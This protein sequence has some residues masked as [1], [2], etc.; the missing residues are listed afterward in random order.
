MA[1][2][3]FLPHHRILLR[4]C[5]DH[6][7]K[8]WCPRPLC[9]PVGPQSS[10]PPRWCP[11]ATQT[12]SAPWSPVSRSAVSNWRRYRCSENTRRTCQRR[13]RRR[14]AVIV[15][16]PPPPT[17]PRCRQVRYLSSRRPPRP[18][19]PSQTLR[20]RRTT[21]PPYHRRPAVR[22]RLHPRLTR[23]HITPHRFLRGKAIPG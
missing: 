12:W 23:P 21:R 5:H 2:A 20:R 4:R 9:S 18:P 3:S 14:R 11:P 15:P 1:A 10:T 7:T 6:L 17:V 13:A 22:C 16:C 19:Q 8:V